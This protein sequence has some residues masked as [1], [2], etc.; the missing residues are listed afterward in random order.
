MPP[1]KNKDDYALIVGINHYRDLNHLEGPENDLKAFEDWLV[2]NDG[3]RLPRKNI[4]VIRSTPDGRKPRVTD[5][6]DWAEDLITEKSPHL[7]ERIGRRLYL[8][9]AGHG[10]G[11]SVNEA[12]LL[13][14]RASMLHVEYFAATR[15]ADFFRQA[16]LFEEVIL[17][18]DCCRD[19]DAELPAPYL[20]LRRTVD[21]GAAHQVHPLYVY[22]TGF[23]RKSREKNF[24]TYVGGVCTAALVEGL[25]RGN[26]QGRVTAEGLKAFVRRRVREL[27]VEGSDQ[28]ADV[29]VPVDFTICEDM[30]PA[31]V[32]ITVSAPGAAVLRVLHSD[33]S[34]T[35]ILP[36]SLEAG[37]WSIEVE[38]GPIYILE[39]EDD[40]ANVRRVA[41]QFSE[42]DTD[43]AL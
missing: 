39:A 40:A 33:F 16:A 41:R 11:P 21:A 8:F 29:L 43:V 17:I 13:T 9:L 25:R 3:G 1:P 35:D 15:C 18:M 26:A 2:A 7:D 23:G 28:E 38:P 36:V 34:P 37:R 5:F 31:L 20:P 19:F 14:P 6:W 32:A 42:E 10:V 27:R 4:T 22:G 30:P 24:G 12:G